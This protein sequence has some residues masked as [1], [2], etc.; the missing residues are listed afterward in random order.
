MILGL[1]SLFT[2]GKSGTRRRLQGFLGDIWDLVNEHVLQP[3]VDVIVDAANAV[4]DIASFILT[5]D[6]DASFRNQLLSISLEK[7]WVCSVSLPSPIL[8]KCARV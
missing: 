4:K 3:V 8:C 5:G 6:L 1:C 7:Q 2:E